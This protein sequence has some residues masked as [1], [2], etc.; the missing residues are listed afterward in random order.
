MSFGP[1]VGGNFSRVTT[2]S[3][4]QSFKEISF[5]K[6]GSVTSGSIVWFTAGLTGE[7]YVYPQFSIGAELL[8]TRTGLYALEIHSKVMQENIMAPIVATY[9]TGKQGEGIRLSLG[10]QPSY[11][12]VTTYY[13]LTG[14][15]EEELNE[16][17]IEDEDDVPK[18]IKL[19]P[20]GL[21]IVSN[22]AYRFS[23]GIEIGMRYSYGLLD[24]RDLEAKHD[25]E[26]AEKVMCNAINNQLYV[27]YNLAK[28]FK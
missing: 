7:F 4:S 23:N 28:L 22:L 27:G 25:S 26:N 21:A 2:S 11:A 14:G 19:K 24:P 6:K 8:Y 5:E 16:E 13:K 9:S 3:P 1:Q 18:A 10:L 12:L 20:F 15:E 17:E